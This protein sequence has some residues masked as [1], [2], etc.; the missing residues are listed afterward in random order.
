MLAESE[1]G[2]EG[3]ACAGLDQPAARE[4]YKWLTDDVKLR[5]RQSWAMQR[6]FDFISKKRIRS[7]SLKTA[8]QELGTWRNQL[9]LE[10]HYGG[11][12]LAEAVRQADNYIKNCRKW[13]DAFVRYNSWTEAENF[14]LVE[15]LVSQSSEEAWREVAESA[16]NSATY[17]LESYRT[18]A[19]RKYAVVHGL[20]LE[21]VD[22]TKVEQSMHGIKGWAEMNVVVAG[23]ND[24]ARDTPN[25][26]IRP[27]A[28]LE[29]GAT[30]GEGG[31][32]PKSKARAKGKAKANSK[33]QSK[34]KVAKK[35]GADAKELEK[36]VRENLMKMQRSQSL[37][38][39]VCGSGSE[40]PS[41]YTWTKPF[42]DEYAQLAKAF[43]DAL[44]PED[45]GE[46]LLPFVNELKLAAL[47]PSALKSTKKAWGD[48]YQNMLTLF[49][50]RCGKA[51]CQ[52]VVSIG[53]TFAF[54]F[55]PTKV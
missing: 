51:C 53:A 10:Q 6:S 38:E 22:I 35:E 55:G 44:T 33:R 27:P 45:G 31:P 32:E 4:T 42:L 17:E 52:P 34:G 9:Q 16:D 28:P 39:N 19:C 7:V 5:F 13:P 23:I 37:M 24:G 12:G 47:S 40:L 30:E 36:E 20:S 29:A 41:E 49:N 43:K 8:N 18:K 3:W 21:A 15:K 11:V 1:E 26:V 2:L 48:K 25:P 54:A 14:L 46:D 50:D